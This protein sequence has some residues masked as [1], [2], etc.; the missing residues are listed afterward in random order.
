M[1]I[2]EWM[3]NSIIEG[4][5]EFESEIDKV[6]ARKLSEN[7]DLKAL[8]ETVLEGKLNQK[9]QDLESRLSRTLG[10]GL[11]MGAPPTHVGSLYDPL[12]PGAVW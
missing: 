4:K 11:P 9:I 5:H 6:I 12:A 3:K 8:V 1:D 2:V 10:K 7:A